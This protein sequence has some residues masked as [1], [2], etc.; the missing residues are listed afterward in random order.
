MRKF[1]AL[2]LII[3]MLTFVSCG[4]LEKSFIS[5]NNHDYYTAFNG[6]NNG[7]KK[8][9]SAC[10]YGLSL[11]YDSPVTRDI[12]S[13]LKYILISEIH[14]N[15]VS[16]KKRLS[17]LNYHF[18]STAIQE[19]KQKLGDELFLR[20]KSK[21]SYIDLDLFI[22]QHQW[23]RKLEEAFQLRDSLVIEQV[24]LNE[25]VWFAMDMAQKYPNSIYMS[26]LKS[27]IDLYEYQNFVKSFNE[28]D[29][30]RFIETYPNNSHVG[31][32]EDSIYAIY[33][34]NSGYKIM[35]EFIEA[36]STNRNISKAWKELYRRYT[37]NFKPELIL[38]F[39][40]EY[41][42]YP[43]KDQITIDSELLK[44]EYYPFSDSSG[45]FGYTDSIGKWLIN[46]TYDDAGFFYN[47]IA[48]VEQN[49]KLGL[50]NKKNE[51][52][53]SFIF[54][55]I[56]TD[57]E[58]F[59]VSSNDHLGIINRNGDFIFDTIFEDISIL[60][61]GFICAQ[62]D[63]LYAF[64]DRNGK[65]LTQEVYDDVLNFKNGVCPVSINGQ[66]GLINKEMKLLIPCMYEGIY[67]Y[68]DSTFITINK[69]DL[70][71]LRNANGKLINDS[72]FQEIHSL[73]NGFAIC[74]KDNRIG[75]LNHKGVQ[76]I[77]NMYEA[78]IDYDI[79][80]N[81]NNGRAV[82]SKDKKFGIIDTTGQFVLKPTHDFIKSVG[83]YYGIQKKDKWTLINSSFETISDNDFESINM[84]R[85]KSLLIENDGRYG[86]MDQELNVIIQCLY[87][88]ISE[89]DDF[90]IISGEEGDALFDYSG[91]EIIPFGN[92]SFYNADQNHLVVVNAETGV[93]YKYIEKEGLRVI[94]RP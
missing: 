22:E 31:I 61:E 68:S 5:L 40:K 67:I 15:E 38:Q 54:D 90:L 17:L 3:L 36:H 77:D 72:L 70:R 92:W 41:T 76:I 65:P 51:Q 59:V 91:S 32:V 35:E 58:L 9:S 94:N 30:T 47:G 93:I 44:I 2:L 52:I 46:P 81:F 13:S 8:D 85:N 73:V 4:A 24:Y 34:R 53:V 50:I 69:D 27:A 86:V 84:L 18:D 1:Y 75:Y 89:I 43:F 21:L 19:Q 82:V 57:K 25:S 37:E 88:S 45:L 79:L 87:A 33:E 7:L 60:D 6:F 14:W 48:G 56:E 20:Y 11:Y 80:G 78:F 42:E 10:A 64:Y 12:D 23:S 66:R 28:G 29:L 39:E 55:E 63:S 16:S 26:E 83:R 49:G 74:I 62:K 71:Q